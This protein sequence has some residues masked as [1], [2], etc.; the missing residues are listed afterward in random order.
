MTAFA[1]LVKDTHGFISAAN[2]HLHKVG[3]IVIALTAN[4]H[5][6]I[7]IFPRQSPWPICFQTLP[8]YLRISLALMHGKNNSVGI[9]KKIAIVF[10]MCCLRSMFTVVLYCI[11]LS[12]AV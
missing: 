8:F 10:A 9:A 3:L 5:G 2:L 7:D 4:G 12:G 1:A 11:V 6:P